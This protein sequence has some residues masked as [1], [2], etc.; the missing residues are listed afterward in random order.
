MPPYPS[1][2]LFRCQ[3]KDILRTPRIPIRVPWPRSSLP[4][5]AK[6]ALNDDVKYAEN[7][8][9]DLLQNFAFH[10]ITTMYNLIDPRKTWIDQFLPRQAIP[11]PTVLLA[12]LEF[13]S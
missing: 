11:L 13:N 12:I 3:R 9:P 5:K 7:L 2:R 8:E 6:H 10:K 4:R 1:R